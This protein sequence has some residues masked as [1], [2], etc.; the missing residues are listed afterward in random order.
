MNIKIKNHLYYTS[1]FLIFLAGFL[2]RLKLLMD[3][4]S[5]WFDESALGYNIF[6]LSYKEMFG[7]LHLQ[8]VAPPF[9]MIVSKFITNMLGIN[10]IKLR[11]F[12]FI[13][14]NL[15]NFIFLFILLKQFN[16]KIVTL[17]GLILICF[18]VELVKYSVEFKP[19][20]AEALSTCL[21]YYLFLNINWNWSYKRFFTLGCIISILPWFAFLSSL[22]IA[23]AQITIISKKMNIKKW[24]I[25]ISPFLISVIFLYMYYVKIHTFY[26]NIMNEIW[27]YYFMNSNNFLILLNNA[28]KYIFSNYF[29]IIFI[30]L[31]LSGLLIAF[32][33][34]QHNYL[35]KYS[36]LVF[37]TFTFASLFKIYP[38]Y[39]RFLLFLIPLLILIILVF[40]E[41][42]LL[43]N[44]IIINTFI[45]V[46]TIIILMPSISFVNKTFNEKYL[47]HSCAKEFMQILNIKKTNKELIFIDSLSICDFLYY[48][49]FYKIDNSL[50][51]NYDIKNNKILYTNN[52]KSILPKIKD[53]YWIFSSYSKV[54]KSNVKYQYAKT[55]KCNNGE[56]ILVNGKD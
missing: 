3:N 30:A 20:I 23:L 31:I 22:L 32:R 44:H 14:G 33:S 53:N 42:L 25:F 37:I 41:N 6:E 34:S 17:L 1:I 7:P 24:L 56:L 16:N 4:P 40:Y 11:L 29:I 43:K 51:I 18:N 48:S 35:A 55:C 8:Q 27:Q 26:G 10:D 47:K 50:I 13:L 19:Y 49:K 28:I 45:S 52:V 21:I 5:F 15:I 36:F 2:L 9:F 12:P 39:E 46:L 38:F 54:D